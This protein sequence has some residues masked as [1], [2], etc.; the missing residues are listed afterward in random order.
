MKLA[1]E[2]SRELTLSQRGQTG[3]LWGSLCRGV[4]VTGTSWREQR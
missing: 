4:G 1:V 3:W 2:K